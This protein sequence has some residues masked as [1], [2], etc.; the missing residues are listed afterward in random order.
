M[1]ATNCRETPPQRMISMMYLVY[2][3]LLALNVSV[4]ILNAFVTVGDSMEVTNRLLA[5]KIDNSYY[6]FEK[7]YNAD[8]DKVDPNWAKAQ[9]VRQETD[10]ILKYIDG[11]K[12]ELG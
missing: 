9:Q 3:A 1:G 5:S 11:I 4:Q 7:A 8:K 10:N 6:A 12:Y 2:T